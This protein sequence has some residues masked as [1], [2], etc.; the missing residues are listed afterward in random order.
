MNTIKRWSILMIALVSI[1]GLSLHVLAN[2]KSNGM[3]SSQSANLEKATNTKVELKG[4]ITLKVK[5]I[6]QYL[7]GEISQEV[8]HQE[9]LS[10]D[11][12]WATYKDWQ[13]IEQSEDKIVFHKLINDIS[14]LLKANGYF[15]IDGDGIIKIFNGKPEEENV[16][17]SFYQ[18]DIKGLESNVREEL[19]KG[20]RV[21]SKD[22]FEKLL[23]DL[24]NYSL[25]VINQD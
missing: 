7:D 13:I 1:I 14:P 15:G 23:E 22:Q 6:R 11:D 17:Q 20:I 24:K 18:I 5:L 8:I 25:E 12:F 2:E 9:I 4:P 10:M 21:R 16:I 19:Q 3:E